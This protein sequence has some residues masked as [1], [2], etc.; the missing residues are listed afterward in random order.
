MKEKNLSKKALTLL[1]AVAM[2]MATMVVPA[3]SFAAE[4]T[5]TVTVQAVEENM[6]PGKTM[7]LTVSS[8][9][10]EAYGYYEDA[11][12]EGKV[13]EV[14][15]MAAY[16]KAVYGA[17]FEADPKAYFNV[18][19][20][21]WVGSVTKMFG[22]ATGNSGF[23]LN[24][25]APTTTIAQTPVTDGDNIVAFL[26]HDPAWG[27]VYYKFS[28]S[29]VNVT[30]GEDVALTLNGYKPMSWPDPDVYGPKEG[31]TVKLTQ[32]AD[33]TVTYEAVTGADGV[34]KFT[35]VKAGEYTAS[36]ATGEYF[37]APYAE[38]KVAAKAAP[39]PAAPA[40]PAAGTKAPDTGDSSD[41]Y[42]WL[43]LLAAA[44]LAVPAVRSKVSK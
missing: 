8:E 7:T 44:A 5:A 15:V 2:V 20:T 17:D 3:A 43:L 21:G 16:H 14:D 36:V 25:V 37:I 10:A 24:N 1:L 33:S 6:T 40:K 32:K 42:M 28:E 22:E 4:E 11:A 23:L 38:V 27:D 9:E 18:A 34:A 13:S 30:E 12:V 26:Y 35:G 39:A 41:M 29:E 19:D 31:I